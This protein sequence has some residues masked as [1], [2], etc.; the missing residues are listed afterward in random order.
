MVVPIDNPR[1]NDAEEARATNAPPAPFADGTT[2][3][4]ACRGIAAVPSTT[5]G[6]WQSLAIEVQPGHHLVSFNMGSVIGQCH[7]ALPVLCK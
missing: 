5:K 6:S 4:A 2:L 1:P 3:G 7:F